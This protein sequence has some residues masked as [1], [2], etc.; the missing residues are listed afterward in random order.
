MPK[1]DAHG[2]LNFVQ[3]DIIKKA[4]KSPGRIF[5]ALEV[6]VD[7][8]ISANTARKYLKDLVNYKILGNYKDGRTI[9]Y[10]SPENLHNILKKAK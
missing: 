3:K 6:S 7:Y 10:I 1:F 9:S 5:T 4:I 2:E 8:D